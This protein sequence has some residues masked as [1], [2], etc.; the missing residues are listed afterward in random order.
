M[1]GPTVTDEGEATVN[2]LMA[3]RAADAYMLADSSKIGQRA[4]A[5]MEGYH[6]QRLITDSG[7]TPDQVE[8][9]AENGIDVLV[10]PNS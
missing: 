5:T 7:I 8:A 3:R 1:V 2:S 10:A 9:F 6:F 4:F